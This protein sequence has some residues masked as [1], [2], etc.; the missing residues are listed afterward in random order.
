MTVS[1]HQLFSDWND[2]RAREKG[3]HALEVSRALRVSEVELV[4]SACGQEA[5]TS[6]IRLS[7]EMKLLLTRLPELGE[8]K[9]VTRNPSAV[10]EV[11]GSYGNVEFFGAMGQSVSSID[12]RIFS[13]R[14]AHAFAVREHTR[15]GVSEGLQFFDAQGRAIHKL[16]LRG[17][18]DRAAYDALVADF[19]SPDQSRVQSVEPV[20]AAPA[21][22]R[23]SDV[24]IVG[25]RDAWA[26]MQDT[27]EFFGMLKRFAVARTRA[28]RLVE[29]TFTE[30]VSRST[31]DQL[32]TIASERE[33]PFMIFVGNAGVV[34]IHTGVVRKVVTLGSWLNVLD[35]G[36][37]VHLLRDDVHEAWIVRKPTVDG[38]VTSLELYDANGEQIAL[39]VG[40]RKP[41]QREDEAWR[42][43]LSAAARAAEVA[44]DEARA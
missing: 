40:K 31:V 39:F 28:L 6:A 16:Y 33:T 5:P 34:Q 4:A 22:V 43:T 42:A 32:F 12:L 35:P 41:G 24:D 37:D 26:S 2:L 9:A 13:A 36:L 23:E 29:G 17:A 30:R 27:H 8:V 44:T 25:L 21:P 15:R 14:W 10:L 19:R 18:S 3:M 7:G 11:L 20:A 38:D 1:P